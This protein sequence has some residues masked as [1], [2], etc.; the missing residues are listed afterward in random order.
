V[1]L[2]DVTIGVL[3]AARGGDVLISSSDSAIITVRSERLRL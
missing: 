3:L 1:T 2:R